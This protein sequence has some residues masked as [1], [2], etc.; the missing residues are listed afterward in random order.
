MNVCDQIR[1]GNVATIA[2]THI[3]VV[4]SVCLCVSSIIDRLNNQF[5]LQIVNN[6]SSNGSTTSRVVECA[7]YR[8]QYYDQN[9][10]INLTIISSSQIELN[11]F[12]SGGA[13]KCET[14]YTHLIRP[15][16]VYADTAFCV[17]SSCTV[18][19]TDHSIDGVSI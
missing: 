12:R 14:V 11:K 2:T 17:S 6:S 9:D 13:R 7:V 4:L 3:C 10:K 19:H 5:R 15:S 16:V 8:K 1:S 18:V